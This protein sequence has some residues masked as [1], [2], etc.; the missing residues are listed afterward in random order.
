ML[1][2]ER[3]GSAVFI[4]QRKYDGRGRR[5]GSMLLAYRSAELTKVIEGRSIACER[6]ESAAVGKLA[7]VDR[8]ANGTEVAHVGT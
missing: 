4:P 3:F 5:L 2:R 8:H 6:V 1:Q 7:E